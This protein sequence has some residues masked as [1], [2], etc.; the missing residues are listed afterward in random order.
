MMIMHLIGRMFGTGSSGSDGLP[1]AGA[2]GI[3]RAPTPEENARAVTALVEPAEALG[4]ELQRARRYEH[5]LSIVLVAARRSTT[6]GEPYPEDVDVDLRRRFEDRSEET[7]PHLA[8]VGLREVLRATDIVCYDELDGRFVLGLTESE[9]PMARRA[10]ARV[11]ELFRRRLQ[12]DLLI[13]VAQF[14]TD[15]LT[16]E[17][18]IETAREQVDAAA[19]GAEEQEHGKTDGSPTSGSENDGGLWPDR[20]VPGSRRPG[21]SSR[22]APAVPVNSQLARRGEG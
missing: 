21:R 10:M 4:D 18:L 14:P 1:S 11:G 20:R 7:V 8:A 17:D 19:E 15:G 2:N 16:L 6:G 12:I 5:A 13:G 22:H 9:R 3:L